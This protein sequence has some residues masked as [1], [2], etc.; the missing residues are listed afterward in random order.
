MN[1]LR[2]FLCSPYFSIK[3]LQRV[4]ILRDFERKRRGSAPDPAP[5]FEKKGGNKLLYFKRKTDRKKWQS[6]FRPRLFYVLDL[7]SYFFDFA[8]YVNHDSGYP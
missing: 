2:R 3:I 4:E 1:G 8:L 7:L 5:F 6:G